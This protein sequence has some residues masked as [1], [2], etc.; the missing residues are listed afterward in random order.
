MNDLLV[1][2]NSDPIGTL[3]A[4]VEQLQIENATMKAEL[5]YW[6]AMHEKARQREET[7]KTF[8]KDSTAQIAYLRKQLYGRKAEQACTLQE[9]STVSGTD[10]SPAVPVKQ[11][12]GQQRGRPSPPMRDQ[13]HLT[14]TEESYELGVH[15]RDCPYCGFPFVPMGK[16]EETELIEIQEVQGYRRIIRRSKYKPSCTCPG[17][18]GIIM[19]QGP[20]KLIP[21][22]RYGASIWIHILTRKFIMQIPVARILSN[23]SLHGLSIP[24]GSVGD[25]L[26]RLAPLFEP[27][28]A[29][30]ETRST[31]ATWWQADE[32]RWRVFETTGSKQNFRWYLWVFISSESIVH[33]IDPT[34]AE[35]VI[36]DH[37]GTMVEGILLVD[38][39]SAYKSYAHKNSKVELAFCWA[40][41]R[42]DFRDAGLSYPELA[43]WAAAWES[44]IG[45][46]FHGNTLRLAHPV[47]SAIFMK[48]E[49]QLRADLAAMQAQMTQE[50]AL[51]HLHH[52]QRSVLK[53]LSNHWEGLMRFVDHPVI[54][55]DNNGSE[56][57]L[58]NPVVGRKNYYGSGSV[59]SARLTAMLFSIFET[60]ALWDL[61]PV[62][63]L[64][65]YFSACALQGGN[66]PASIQEH[67]PWNISARKEPT[68]IG[69]FSGRAFTKQEL[70]GIIA[71]LDEQ[72]SLTRTSLAR[73][74]CEQLS[75]RQADGALK[76]AH[77]L[78]ALRKMEARGLVRLP[79]SAHPSVH[80]ATV[81]VHTERT[82]VGHPL[83]GSV[84]TLPALKITIATG[85]EE[86]SLWAEYI[87][88]YHYLGY[89]RTTGAQ[90]RYF[91]HSGD[92]LVALLGFSASA[93]KIAPRDWFIGWNEAQRFQHLSLVVNNSR[94]LILPWVQVKN[95]ASKALSMVSNRISDDW[96]KR[97]KYRPVLLETFVEKHRFDGTCYKAANW[98]W[99]G[100]TKGRGKNDR[101]CEF[102]IPK[103]EI[104][105]YPLVADFK[106]RLIGS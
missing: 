44:R 16:P 64:H 18:K 6:K 82:A 39:Y 92:S 2:G 41:V 58:R 28:Y 48:E 61:N 75:W 49:S 66:A 29:A 65:D 13:S 72:T 102:K 24:P 10:G 30:L 93:L 51:P 83:V 100:T 98:I 45:A 97:Y 55:M 94:F 50:L 43:T 88:R 35:K 86:R 52:E 85:P 106:A 31:E 68:P 14:A 79:V 103:K 89:A 90:L 22:S 9:T 8:L 63:W 73:M 23:M 62:T 78:S 21:G 56:R 20:A 71:L 46:L 15:E 70:D 42:R 40:H 33:V 47:G 34:R 77:M 7:L 87:D 67:L 11:P 37:L 101:L 80:E 4:R 91:V 57:I 32:T 36:E 38:R 99:V 19:A 105:L 59:G 104:L 53:S 76:L 25:G 96:E 54:P 69:V 81:I 3:T 74:L 12:R 60:L 95:L 84:D 1:V 5:A 26:K 27:I 17:N